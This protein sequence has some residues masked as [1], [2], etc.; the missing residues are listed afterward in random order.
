MIDVKGLK[1]YIGG[2]LLFNGIDLSI[3]KGDVIVLIGPS[4]SG[5]SSLMRCITGLEPFEQGAVQVDSIEVKGT[6]SHHWTREDKE[7]LRKVRIKVGMVFQQFNLFPHMTVLG[8]VIEA[9]IHVLQLSCA[10]AIARARSVLGK[11]NMLDFVDRYP[12]TLSG[13]EKQRVAIARALAMNPECI[14]FDEPTSALDPEMVGEVLQ[15]MRDLA[16][17]GMTMLIVTHEMTFAREVSDQVL[18]LDNG[19]IIERGLPDKIFLNPEH[20]RTRLF[21]KRVLPRRGD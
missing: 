11:V 21:L 1:K 14:L 20:E 12:A 7:L 2:R 17:E 15:V 18:V 5:K 8:N 19:E 6:A 9:P 10:E 13:G 3:D 4:G 16:D